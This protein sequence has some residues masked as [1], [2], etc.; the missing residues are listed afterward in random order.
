MKLIRFAPG[1]T[2]PGFGVVIGE[3]AVAFTSLQQ[4]SGITQPDV[5]DMSTSVFIDRFDWDQGVF[6]S[7]A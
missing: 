6:P 1:D 3:R 7:I 5:R 2:Q 4:R